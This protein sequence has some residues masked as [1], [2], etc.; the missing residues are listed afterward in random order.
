MSTFV[1]PKNSSQ[2]RYILWLK[3][4]NKMKQNINALIN[5]NIYQ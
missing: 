5:L 4:I 3:K 1:Y 2:F